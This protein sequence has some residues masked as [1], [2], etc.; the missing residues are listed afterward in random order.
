MRIVVGKTGRFGSALHESQKGFRRV[1]GS[2]DMKRL[3]AA[4]DRRNDHD[5]VE[6]KKKVA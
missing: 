6:M 5:G 4:L 2:R 1:K 3:V